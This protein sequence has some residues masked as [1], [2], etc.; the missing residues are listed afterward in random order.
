MVSVPGVEAGVRALIE[1]RADITGSTNVGMSVVAE[2]DAG[3]GARYI[4]FDPSPEAFKRMQDYFPCYPVQVKPGPGMVGV[5]EPVT[6]MAYNFYLVSSEKLSNETAYA[7]IKTLWEY[8]KELAPIH[9]R[10][11]DWTRNR[12]VTT[13]ATIPYHPGAIKFYK[14]IGAWG[15][16]MDNLQQQLLRQK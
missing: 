6:L 13:K 9:V 15:A 3:K 16:E 10:L 12:Y 11:K 1:G 2:L 4:S 5:K 8:D 7:I 14:E